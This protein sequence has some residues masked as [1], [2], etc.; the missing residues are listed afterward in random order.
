MVHIPKERRLKWDKKAKQCILVGYPDDVKGYRVYNP[1]NN[2]ITTSRD[3]VVNEEG[4]KKEQDEV[5]P[6]HISQ[7]SINFKVKKEMPEVSAETSGDTNQ[8][9]PDQAGKKS[10]EET[11]VKQEVVPGESKEDGEPLLSVTQ[12]DA[13]VSSHNSTANKEFVDVSDT[14]QPVGVAEEQE[15][16]LSTR[17]R[18]QPGRYGF[19]SVCANSE[20]DLKVFS[21]NRL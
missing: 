13:S 1:N 6:V 14:Q 7:E 2:C 8:V 20:M 19:S 17:V 12:G 11:S 10:P 21:G 5:V 18:K 9:I 16:S 15:T 3:V 4:I